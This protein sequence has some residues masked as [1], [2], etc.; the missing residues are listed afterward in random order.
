ML[1][2][3]P[4]PQLRAVLAMVLLSFGVVAWAQRAPVIELVQPVMPTDSV[5]RTTEA[6]IA[7]GGRV[8]SNSPVLFFRINTTDVVVKDNGNFWQSMDLAP[9][10]NRVRIGVANKAGMMRM[11]DFTVV[12]EAAIAVEKEVTKTPQVVRAEERMDVPTPEANKPVVYMG[13]E[14]DEGAAPAAPLEIRA[15]IIAV[16]KHKFGAENDLRYPAKDAAVFYDFITSPNGL[17]ADPKNVRLLVDENATREAIIGAMRDMMNGANSTDVFFL[18]FSGHGQSVDNGQEYYFF[19]HDTRTTDQNTIAASAL[20]RSEVRTRLA[21]GK[22]RKKVLFLDACY[23]GMMAS[24]GKSMGERREHLFQEMAAT[25]EALVVFTSSSDTER[26]FED[27]TLD[28]GH[29]IFTYYVVK[30]LQ[31]EADK[32]RTGNKDGKVTVYELDRYLGETVN[33]RAL[34]TKDQPQR[35]K[36]DCER[37]EDFPLSVT[38]DYD[39]STAKPR[40]VKEVEWT[41]P[42]PKVEGKPV[43]KPADSPSGRTYETYKLPPVRKE[44]YKQPENPRLLNAQVYANTSTGDKIT[45]YGQYRERI[46]LTGILGGHVLSAPGTMQGIQIAFNDEASTD[47]MTKGFAVFS[48]DSSSLNVTLELKAGGKERYTLQRMGVAVREQLPERRFLSNEDGTELCVYMV[49]RE[50]VGISGQVGGRVIDAR[51]RIQGDVI[52]FTDARKDSASSGQLVLSDDWTTAQGVVAFGTGERKELHFGTSYLKEGYA[53]NN[54][55]YAN[56]Q[57]DQTINFHDAYRNVIKLSGIVGEGNVLCTGTVKGDVV[58]L[59]D[60]PQN[61]TFLPSKLVL[62]NKGQLLQGEVIFKDGTVVKVNMQRKK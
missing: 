58:S 29:G 34:S 25:D 3:L 27:E 53:L 45:F 7:V 32:V 22:V 19:T 31:G 33:E 46:I 41:T 55:I 12:R 44:V 2:V 48:P 17:A 57:G 49:Y 47:R 6:R 52:M 18:Y 5:V 26:S 40:A 28:G 35:P 61:P 23:S 54:S 15:L 14:G 59:N 36:R 1:P 42:P 60:E 51:G 43:A 16:G 37:C 39:I 8:L 62:R 30:G 24:G 11:V 20:S 9:G 21:N 4:F 10:E 50:D 38:T 13:R 56:R